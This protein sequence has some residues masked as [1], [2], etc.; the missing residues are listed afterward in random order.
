[1]NPRA[2]V[3]LADSRSSPGRSHSAISSKLA[4]REFS[5]A[6]SNTRADPKRQATTCEPFRPCALGLAFAG[7]DKM[8]EGTMAR[9]TRYCHPMASSRVS[10]L[11][12]MAKPSSQKGRAFHAAKHGLASGASRDGRVKSAT[13]A[14]PSFG[15]LRVRGREGALS[16]PG[17]GADLGAGSGAAEVAVGG[18]VALAAESARWPYGEL[19]WPADWP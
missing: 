19:C 14:R 10:T 2:P 18:G 8:E 7:V 11:L 4:P 9:A 16:A 1:M 17:A 15:W 12:A 13:L 6:S 3:S 5:P